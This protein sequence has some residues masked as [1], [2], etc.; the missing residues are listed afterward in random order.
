MVAA[1]AANGNEHGNES[2]RARRS[3]ADDHVFDGGGGSGNTNYR[4]EVEEDNI[5]GEGASD[6][7]ER[8]ALS[9]NN[10]MVSESISIVFSLLIV[11]VCNSQHIYFFII[12]IL[13]SIIRVGVEEGECP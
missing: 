7:N 1:A 4:N 12:H 9:D 6:E 2:K 5:E 13:L 8:G 10:N 11:V 3:Y